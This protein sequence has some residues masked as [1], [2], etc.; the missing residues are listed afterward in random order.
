M[1]VH[2]GDCCQRPSGICSHDHRPAPVG[3]A[4]PHSPVRRIFL[5]DAI[6]NDKHGVR[7]AAGMTDAHCARLGAA[8][9]K[10]WWHCLENSQKNK[11]AYKQI[12]CRTYLFIMSVTMLDVMVEATCKF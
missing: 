9:F 5:S 2:L 8:V 10:T 12:T 1:S 6:S 7:C 3:P 4:T 11:A